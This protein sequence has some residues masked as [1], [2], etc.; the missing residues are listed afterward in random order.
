MDTGRAVDRGNHR[1]IDIKDGLQQ[2]TAFP[3]LDVPALCQGQRRIEADFG[4]TIKPGAPFLAGP[5]QDDDTVC[6]IGTNPLKSAEQ[7]GARTRAEPE[8]A[9]VAVKPHFEN[10]VMAAVERNVG[11]FGKVIGRHRV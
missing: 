10:A 11:K 3:Q 5:G 4:G 7:L 8:R 6:T 1:R 2:A 9:T